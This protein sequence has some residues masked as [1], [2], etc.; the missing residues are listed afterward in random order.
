M[1]ELTLAE[2]APEVDVMEEEPIAADDEGI[3]AVSMVLGL[4]RVGWAAE[5]I[6][7]ELTMGI[8]DVMEELEAGL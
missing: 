6:K 2:D 8:E 5:D 4:G 7:E 3:V 1:E